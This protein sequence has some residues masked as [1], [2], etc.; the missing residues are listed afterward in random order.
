VNSEHPLFSFSTIHSPRLNRRLHTHLNSRHH[1]QDQHTTAPESLH[2]HEPLPIRIQ[3]LKLSTAWK[4]SIQI[5]FVVV[6]PCLQHNTL[7]IYLLNYRLNLLDYERDSDHVH[8]QRLPWNLRLLQRLVI[9]LQGSNVRGL[10][11]LARLTKELRRRQLQ[12]GET[13]RREQKM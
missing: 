8:L 7:L 5:H 13:I 4:V 10:H 6:L 1:R 2:I 11:H 9:C 3:A 12:Q